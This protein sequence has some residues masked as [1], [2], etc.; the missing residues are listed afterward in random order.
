MPKDPAEIRAEID[1][2]R[3]ELTTDANRLTE[4][5][6]PSKVVER[7]VEGVKEAVGGV[8]DKVFGTAGGAGTAVSGAAGSVAGAGS[9]AVHGVGS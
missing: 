1:R 8:K 5:V 2:T 9:S 3:A 7:K 4:K 6:T